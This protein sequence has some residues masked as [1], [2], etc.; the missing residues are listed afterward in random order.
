MPDLA[1]RRIVVTG[2]GR[3]IGH[4]IA[5]ACLDA[6]GIVGAG[7]R[8]SDAEIL[9]LVERHGKRILP[10]RFDVR[11]PAEVAH[12][13]AGFKAYCGGI[14][15]WVNAAGVNRPGLL[16]QSD[17][18]AVRE[19]IDTNLLGPIHA[20]RAVLPI[21]LEQRGGVLVNVSS[22]AAVRPTRGQAAYA[23]SK[24]AVEALTRALAIEYGR[25][26]VRVVCIR[27]GPIETDMLEAT[28]SLAGEEVLDRVALRR[29]GRPAEVAALAVFLLSDDAAFVTGSV[30]A[31]DG[32]YVE[33]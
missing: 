16:V 25:K 17:A 14:D 12:A 15:G 4:A 26:G 5:L 28:K 33:P 8:S 11:D 29:F 27:P 30:H 23:A 2:A 31:I 21:M 9:A 32:G 18:D 19:T 24:A 3:G 7:Y 13:A 22:V 1:G 6:G 10:L 20:A